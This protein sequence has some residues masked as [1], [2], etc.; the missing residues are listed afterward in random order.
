MKGPISHNVGIKVGSFFWWIPIARIVFHKDYIEL[1][2]NALGNYYFLPDD[3]LTIKTDGARKGL[4]KTVNIKHDIPYYPSRISIIWLG[5]VSDILKKV[6][7]FVLRKTQT[8]ESIV[9][10]EIKE[11]QKSGVSPFKK[12]YLVFL[13]ILFCLLWLFDWFRFITVEE[14]FFPFGLG[15]LSILF[16]TIIIS[17]LSLI[18][19]VYGRILLKNNRTIKDIDRFYYLLIFFCICILLPNLLMRHFFI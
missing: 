11:K 4:L 12:H 3:I 5:D 10:K 16:I 6:N 7:Q 14:I 1:N 15:L 13:S 19:P 9:L 17:A 2:G 18:F 8:V